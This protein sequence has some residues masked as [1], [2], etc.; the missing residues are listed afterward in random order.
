MTVNVTAPSPG[1]A[2]TVGMRRIAVTDDI[3]IRLRNSCAHLCDRC[4]RE[5]AYG[6]GG[7]AAD[8]IESLRH[9][10]QSVWTVANLLATRLENISSG[11]SIALREYDQLREETHH[12]S[13]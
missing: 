4:E 2:L 13:Q 3:V 11:I 5:N 9:Q 10:L 6:V 7:K 8:E 12:D 1:D